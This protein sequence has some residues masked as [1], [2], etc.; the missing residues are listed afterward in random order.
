MY[1][2]V[3]LQS[4][5]IKREKKEKTLDLVNQLRGKGAYTTKTYGLSLVRGMQGW[6]EKTPGVVLWLHEPLWHMLSPNGHRINIRKWDGNVDSTHRDIIKTRWKVE[7]ESKFEIPDVFSPS[8]RVSWWPY[9]SQVSVLGWLLVGCSDI[10]F[11]WEVQCTGR[12]ELLWN[13]QFYICPFLFASLIINLSSFSWA[14][15]LFSNFSSNIGP[16]R[17]T[18][19]AKLLPVS[20]KEKKKKDTIFKINRYPWEPS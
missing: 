12:V 17:R 6:K 10:L 9:G 15:F 3:K 11:Y 14:L 7:L 4:Q 8:F 2:I 1:E 20:L 16:Q 13:C 5:W 19:N 18:V